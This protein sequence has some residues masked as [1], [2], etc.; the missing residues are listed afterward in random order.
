MRLLDVSTVYRSHWVQG[1]RS[2][3]HLSL[4]QAALAQGHTFDI[5]AKAKGVTDDDPAVVLRFAD[6]RWEVVARETADHLHC[7]EPTIV[8]VYEGCTAAVEA[9]A[10]VA[11]GLPHHTFL[12]NLFR[13]EF[14]SRDATRRAAEEVFAAGDA[15]ETGSSIVA[16]PSNLRVLADTEKRALLA[17]GHGMPVVGSWPHHTA[18]DPSIVSCA[19]EP[20]LV[21]IAVA[22]WQLVGDAETMRDIGAV[23]GRRSDSS[24]ELRFRLLGGV[25]P[26]SRTRLMDRFRVLRSLPGALDGPLSVDDYASALGSGGLVWLP[27]Q[28]MYRDQSSGKALDAMVLGRPLLAPAGTFPQQEQERLIPGA[29]TYRNRDELLEIFDTLPVIQPSLSE[30]AAAMRPQA[31]QD[32]SADHAIERLIAFARERG[33][34]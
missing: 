4:R 17:R 18:I 2:S 23:L 32:Y 21:V 3:F 14:R 29:P 25:P 13:D 20:D 1:H 28:R 16:L 15:A 27:T 31:A 22:A 26:V 7:R 19:P 34:P 9:F 12:I 10:G 24:R 30:A 6:A 5:A 8:F 11:R 33:S